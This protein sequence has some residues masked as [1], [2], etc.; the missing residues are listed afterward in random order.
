MR[1]DTRMQ[2]YRS[3]PEATAAAFVD[4]WYR[5]GDVA[6]ID[7][8][9]FLYIVDRLKDVIIVGGE[10]VYSQEVEEALRA[11]PRLNDV[12]VIG[13]PD[14]AWGEVVVAV[15]VTSDGGDLG[16]EDIREFLSDKLA[17]YKVPREAITVDDL[18]R[19]PSGKLTKHVI[20]KT[21]L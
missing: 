15:V 10:N 16:I 18:P 5:T 1:G 17:R 20:R 6:R 12:A 9:G 3:N 19:N 7:E 11:H 13:R 8:D 2:A 14:P 4:D 21:V